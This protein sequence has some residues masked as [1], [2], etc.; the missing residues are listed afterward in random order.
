MYRRERSLHP[1]KRPIL[2]SLHTHWAGLT[3]FVARPA[4]A[5]DNNAAE[6]ALRNPVV[7]RK[8]S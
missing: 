8:N 5:M 4:V 6:R 1:A 3:I 2:D 7:G